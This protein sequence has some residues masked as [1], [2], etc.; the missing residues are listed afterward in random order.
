MATRPEH[1]FLYPIDW[2]QLSHL[3]RFVRQAPDKC[4]ARLWYLSWYRR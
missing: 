1:L 2:P 3:V 4:V